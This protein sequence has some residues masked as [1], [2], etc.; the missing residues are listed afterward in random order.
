MTG[1]V[2]DH[3]LK[4]CVFE[5]YKMVIERRPAMTI[6]WPAVASLDVNEAE[7]DELAIDFRRYLLS[8]AAWLGEESLVI[9]LLAEGCNWF[10]KLSLFLD[11]IRA[12][13]Y[14]GYSLYLSR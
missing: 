7:V 14:R 10:S 1:A 13:S 2:M 3:E 5:V 4:E 6:Y 11:P 12:A 9:K 8:A